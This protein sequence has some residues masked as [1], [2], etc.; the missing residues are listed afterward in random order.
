[1]T[2]G[3]LLLGPLLRYVDATSATV[4]VET[5]SR[6]QVSVHLGDSTWSAGTFAVHGHH[7]ALVE[8]TGLEPGTTMPYS[9]FVDDQ[10]VWPEPDSP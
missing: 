6:A 3:P 2:S 9:L 8:V 1:M 4:W 10:Q 5:R 7:Y